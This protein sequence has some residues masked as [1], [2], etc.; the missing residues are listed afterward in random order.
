MFWNGWVEYDGLVVIVIGV[1][2]GRLLRGVYISFPASVAVI[3]VIVAISVI[4]SRDIVL[5]SLVIVWFGVGD[6]MLQSI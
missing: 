4:F 1:D 6:F 5:V 2:I 3:I